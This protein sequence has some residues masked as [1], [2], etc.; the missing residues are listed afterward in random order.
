MVPFL[1]PLINPA[2]RFFVLS[3]VQEQF[4]QGLKAFPLLIQVHLGF[5]HHVHQDCIAHLIKHHLLGQLGTKSAK[6]KKGH[7]LKGDEATASE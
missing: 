7:W 5:P 1:Q 2:Y 4:C 3:N 6:K